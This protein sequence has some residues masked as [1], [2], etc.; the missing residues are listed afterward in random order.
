MCAAV[1][2]PISH[3]QRFWRPYLA[4]GMEPQPHDYYASFGIGATQLRTDVDRNK[5]ATFA[6]CQHSTKRPHLEFGSLTDQE[7]HAYLNDPATKGV[8]PLQL[9]HRIPNSH[10]PLQIDHRIPILPLVQTPPIAKNQQFMSF[11]SNSK[12]KGRSIEKICNK[13]AASNKRVTKISNAFSTVPGGPASGNSSKPPWSTS[14]DRSTDGSEEL[15]QVQ[16]FYCHAR[17]KTIR[18]FTATRKFQASESNSTPDEHLR[19]LIMGGFD[20]K[21]KTSWKYGIFE[22]LYEVSSVKS[23]WKAFDATPIR[24]SSSPSPSVRSRKITISNPKC[25]SGEVVIKPVDR[26]ERR[27]SNSPTTLICTAS[28]EVQSRDE[29]QQM[30]QAE[31]VV[32]EKQSPID[33]FYFA[34][35]PGSYK[36]KTIW[37]VAHLREAEA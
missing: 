15:H 2:Y 28:K 6:H 36:I 9:D 24:R 32:S 18:Y 37:R 4:D 34:E 12:P 20:A 1:A 16:E 19:K 11:R 13:P 29:P 14:G 21:R 30:Q 17:E 23:Q 3:K 33:R 31:P 10:L 7:R 26:L 27:K 5:S 8:I 25:G 35:N 22:H